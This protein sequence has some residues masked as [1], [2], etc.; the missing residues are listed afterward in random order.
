[1][2]P[3]R[4]EDAISRATSLGGH[5]RHQRQ[6]LSV[7]AR[8][9]AAIKIT[10]TV[11]YLR[12]LTNAVAGGVLVALYLVVLVLQLN[13][14]VPV[15]SLT[16]GRWFVALIAFYGPYATSVI[17]FLILL[18]EALAS[19]PLSP[20]WFSVRLMAWLGAAI[21][22]AAAIVTWANLRGF[23]AVLSAA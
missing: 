22:A 8:T 5:P 20:A 16:A 23:R 19:R 12:M 1:M 11:R 2:K 17:Y 18:R 15:V 4:T 10:L 13:P 9:S 21:G 6:S 7:T 3:E 14:Q